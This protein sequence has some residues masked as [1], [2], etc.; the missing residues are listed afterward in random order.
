MGETIRSLL[1][2]YHADGGLRGELAY[3]FGKLRGTAHCALC[4][5]SHRGVR[6]R[7]EWDRLPQRLGVPVDV[8]HLNERTPDVLRASEGRTPCVLARTG[9]GLVVLL[10]PA[11]L[12]PLRGDVDA[13]AAALVD[14]AARAGLGWDA[15][16]PA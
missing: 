6:R 5:L 2:V 11:E 16:H 13:L 12:E 4:D 9:G 1:G 8:V 3:A 15:R 7:R 10:G 14:A